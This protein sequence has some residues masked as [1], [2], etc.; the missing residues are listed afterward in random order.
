MDFGEFYSGNNFDSY[1]WLGA[2]PAE[3][4]T[5]FRV[6]A[7]NADSVS[8][9]GEFNGWT[10]SPMSPVENGKFWELFVEGAKAG[11]MYKYRISSGGEVREHCDPFGFGMEL[12]PNFASI[13]RKLDFEFEDE[14]WLKSRPTWHGDALNIYEVHL[15]SWKTNPDSPNGWYSYKEI[16]P[17]LVS[18]CKTH[19][20]NCVE[21]M[22]LNEYPCDE[23]W[24]YQATGFFAPTSRY[25]TAE[26]LKFLVNYCH[27]NGIAVF[28]DFVPVH[29]AVDGY[30]LA[31][32]DGSPLFESK[33]KDIAFSEWG[34]RNFD[35]TNPIVCSF[36]KSAANYWLEE[37]HFDGLRMDAISRVIFWGG[38]PSRG[39][40]VCGTR[41][42]K[43]MNL[44][45]KARH[46]SAVLC[47]EDSTDFARVTK[48]VSEGGL[49]FDY[50]WDMGW[51]N[52]TLDYF[53]MSPADRVPAYHKLTF[54]MMY[55]YSEKFIL[56]LSHDENVHGKATIVQKMYGLYGDKFPQ[57]RALYM[58]M[59]AHPGKK[60]NF[61]GN[62]LGQLREW[63][64]KREQDW[65]VL[66]YPQHD[67]FYRFM[68]KLCGIYLR[69]PALSRW[70]DSFEGFRWLECDSP[71]K[72]CYALQRYCPEEKPIVAVFNFS[73]LLQLDYCFNIGAGNELRVILD[74]TD[75]R[76]S[77]CAPHYP[78]TL[79]ADKFGN[80]RF[81]VPRYSAAYFE[82]CSARVRSK[83]RGKGR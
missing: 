53:R 24:G 21:V 12:R 43:T 64:E 61:M 23:S 63:D 57:A 73:D 14:K 6:F 3:N 47:A 55:N 69:K 49:G 18:Y 65:Q 1:K 58:Y 71:L 78:K 17:W 15:G 32:F 41:F 25:G 36:L 40:N 16:A 35:F 4:G 19:G 51:M 28:M 30:A 56:P 22:P 31:E 67:S 76:W 2:H 54:S 74:S 72:R 82:L 46:P 79:R 75:D 48:A 81:D 42:L 80:V 70:D 83:K 68:S 38:D 62:E 52:D 11:Q 5:V 37:Y 29:F 34:S 10:D 8:V 27:K 44:G 77:G 39:E 9:I 45:L 7:P 33:F 26:E 20:Y 13:I 59:Y 66:D 60:L 50:K